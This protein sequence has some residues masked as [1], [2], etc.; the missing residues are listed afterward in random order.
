MPKGIGDLEHAN[1]S[2]QRRFENAPPLRLKDS[3]PLIDGMVGSI[4]SG[5]APPLQP[6]DGYHAH[7]AHPRSRISG[8]QVHPLRHISGGQL[9]RLSLTLRSS[10]SRLKE[11]Q[12]FVHTASDPY[13]VFIASLEDWCS[14]GA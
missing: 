8:G 7:L 12:A 2:D 13:F 9:Y 14:F 3:Q 11:G 6:F 10:G 5:V 4:Y 1:Q